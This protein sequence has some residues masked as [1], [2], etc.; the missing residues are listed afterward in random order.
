MDLRRLLRHAGKRLDASSD[1]PFLLADW[2]EGEGAVGLLAHL[3]DRI[4]RRPP[5]A[6]GRLKLQR[7][8]H[9]PGFTSCFFHSSALI[10]LSEMRYT[11]LICTL[12]VNKPRC[13][14][15][16][17]RHDPHPRHQHNAKSP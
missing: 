13:L 10:G 7:S 6:R 5:W 17:G 11:A 1:L 9:H 14:P 8:T 3:G 16:V 15:S 2:G 4:E 12:C